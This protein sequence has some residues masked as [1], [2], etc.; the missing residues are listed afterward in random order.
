MLCRI[1]GEL[2]NQT[3]LSHK[4]K[5]YPQSLLL[6]RITTQLRIVVAVFVLWISDHQ[7]IMAPLSLIVFISALDFRFILFLIVYY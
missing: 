6:Y 4:I 1:D 3:L 5:D 2:R 7:N